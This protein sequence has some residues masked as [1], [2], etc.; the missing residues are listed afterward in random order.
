MNKF[1]GR[2]TKQV[3]FELQNRLLAGWSLTFGGFIDWLEWYIFI[4]CGKCN[5]CTTTG[6]CL[7]PIGSGQ[8]IFDKI[9]HLRPRSPFPL[10]VTQ[11]HNDSLSP[12]LLTHLLQRCHL[13]D[14][15][16]DV[17]VVV[18]LAGVLAAGLLVNASSAPI[19]GLDANPLRPPDL[20]AAVGA[21]LAGRLL[22]KSLVVTVTRGRDRSTC[23]AAS[24]PAQR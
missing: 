17:L 13:S 5:V 10:P 6:T 15:Q 14:H 21:G 18:L 12:N 9:N 8:G 11:H 3:G 22:L 24:G 2:R 16:L 23:A 20:A 1:V 7:Q 4:Y 19:E